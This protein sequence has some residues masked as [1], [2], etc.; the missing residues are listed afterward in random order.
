[1]PEV[2]HKD[3]NALLLHLY[4][5]VQEPAE[6]QSLLRHVATVMDADSVAMR[7]IGNN[8]MTLK[9]SYSYGLYPDYCTD[10]VRI[11]PFLA[12][13][14]N[15]NQGRAL[16][17]QQ[18]FS[19]EEYERTEHYQVFFQPQDR[20]YAMGTVLSSGPGFNNYIGLHRSRTHGH[21][22]R[23]DA[24]FMD[25]FT[26]HL[27]Q[28]L[29]LQNQLLQVQQ[30]VRYLERALGSLATGVW[31]L[32]E[33]LGIEWMNT[34]GYDVVQH[35][36]QGFGQTSDRRLYVGTSGGPVTRSLQQFLAGETDRDSLWL[37]LP[38]SEAA[39]LVFATDSAGL[40]QAIGKTGF[41]QRQAVV[42]LLDSQRP[43]IADHQTLALQY[44]LSV[45]ESRLAQML[46]LGCDL[47]ESADRLCISPH[48]ARTHLKSI[49]EKTGSHRQAELI[50]K[51][52]VF[53][54]FSQKPQ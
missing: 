1:M 52:M 48:T 8:D 40:N 15:H 46:L 24:A 41:G 33:S 23:S 31:L 10:L 35:N 32:N 17:S 7:W 43:I 5:C 51:L 54:S 50:Q 13:L 34:V 42:I 37:T 19:D 3:F 44:Q 26:P 25:A 12:P 29:S 27:Q 20:F 6:W 39:L 49:F 30:T 36:H 22:S 2:S 53:S 38:E 18:C 9:R 28:A 11:D 16:C 45:A 14:L 21:F 47:S 4:Q